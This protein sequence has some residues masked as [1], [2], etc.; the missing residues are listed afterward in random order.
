MLGVVD[1][2]QREQA[3]TIADSYLEEIFAKP[4]L[5]PT[6]QTVCPAPPAGGRAFYD[7]VCDYNGLHDVGAYDQNGNAI[8]G[9][10]NYTINV[11]VTQNVTQAYYYAPFYS[12]AN[13]GNTSV[14]TLEIDVVITFGNSYN[15][16]QVALS[17]YRV[18]Y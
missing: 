5:D 3:V 9:L 17:G 11:T 13:T 16:Q 15:Q 14:G 12:M 18:N 10:A 7:N 1:P 2:M 8:T 4:Y 6:T